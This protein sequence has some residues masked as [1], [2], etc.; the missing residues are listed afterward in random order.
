MGLSHISS[1]VPQFPTE[2]YIIGRQLYS[3]ELKKTMFLHYY[4]VKE[5][6]DIDNLK[7]DTKAKQPWSR[8]HLSLKNDEIDIWF[9]I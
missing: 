7:L 9:L 5:A 1:S 2:K 4:L 8:D 6:Y 3:L